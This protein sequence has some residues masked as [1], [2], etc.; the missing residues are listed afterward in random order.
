MFCK[1][2]GTQMNDGTKFCPSCGANQD[3]QQSRGAAPQSS[4]SDVEQNKGMAILSYLGFLVLIPFF[5]ATHSPFAKYHAT[6]GLNLLILE[7]IYGIGVAIL[8][9]I[10]FAISFW[11]G[12]TISTILWIGWLGFGIL[13]II[14]IINAA[15]GQMKP[16][17]VVGKIQF[18]K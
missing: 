12:A 14:G 11:L 3:A 5:A 13:S 1:N 9:A 8:T 4:Q 16:L 18:I 7:V 6:Q 15:N 2:C 10:F 17:P